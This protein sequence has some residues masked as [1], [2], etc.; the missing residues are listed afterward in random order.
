LGEGVNISTSLEDFVHADN[1]FAPCEL[2]DIDFLCNQTD[3]N[4]DCSG[5]NGPNSEV[6]KPVSTKQFLHFF[7]E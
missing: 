1:N 5:H 3:K 4:G 2:R 7:I 6:Y